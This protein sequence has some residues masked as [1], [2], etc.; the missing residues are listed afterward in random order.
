MR[1]VNPL[2]YPPPARKAGLGEG[3]AQV[4]GA[5]SPAKL[6]P[7][8][9]PVRGIFTAGREDGRQAG[10][11]AGVE[12]DRRGNALHLAVEGFFLPSPTAAQV[13]GA[14]SPVKLEAGAGAFA[15]EGAGLPRKAPRTSYP[16]ARPGARRFSPGQA[17]SPGRVGARHFHR[18]E[19]RRQAEERRRGVEQDRRGNA[20]HLALEGFLILSP[21]TRQLRCKALPPRRSP[22]PEPELLPAKARACTEKRLAPRTRVVI[23][24]ALPYPAGGQP[25]QP[26]SSSPSSPSC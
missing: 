25:F 18:R 2:P 19:G 23:H 12:Q 4:Q 22:K 13:Q 24:R 11:R 9:G 8:A 14:S 6:P 21:T 17:P 3:V 26:C 20:L 16:N 1:Q 7:Q 10:G 15:R 5:S